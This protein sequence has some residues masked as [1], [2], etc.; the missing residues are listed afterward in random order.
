MQIYNDHPRLMRVAR[1]FARDYGLRLPPGFEQQLEGDQTPPRPKAKTLAEQKQEERTGQ[2]KAER[3]A[4]LTAAWQDYQQD[5]RAFV[6]AIGRAGFALA[7][8]DG[9]QRKA[10]KESPTV[11]VVIDRA[12]EVH[13][14]ARQIAGAKSRE[15]AALLGDG[16]ALD[17]L[18]GVEATRARLDRER[19]RRAVGREF[20]RAAQAPVQQPQDVTADKV[21]RAAANDNRPE[22]VYRDD[23]DAVWQ[24]A[25]VDGAIKADAA[26]QAAERDR[27]AAERAEW[28][29]KRKAERFAEKVDR[30]EARL[31]T[32]RAD[33]QTRHHAEHG[34]FQDRAQRERQ[35]LQNYLDQHYNGTTDELTR[36]IAVLSQQK[37]RFP[38]LWARLTG[39]AKSQAERLAEARESLEN[40]ASRRA[41][42]QQALI[43][44]QQDAEW[45]LLARQQAE[46]QR[47][48][49]KPDYQELTDWVKEYR[50][51]IEQA[52]ARKEARQERERG[53]RDFE[54]PELK[55]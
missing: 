15:I 10:G 1:D 14:L 35:A 51:G 17:S 3:A 28:A 20:E 55:P 42:R 32:T 18:D 45:E 41:E 50:A 49:T 22:T 4:I 33:L 52:A 30:V 34:A 13:S 12:G 40:V 44:Q 9:Q 2:S 47:L 39:K 48:E 21:R 5:A 8:G 43:R 25:L 7:R 27:R 6:E 16:Y 46:V 23:Q 36:E 29:A 31:G 19:Q 11:Y 53:G 38:R 26:Q 54:G 24:E 37:G